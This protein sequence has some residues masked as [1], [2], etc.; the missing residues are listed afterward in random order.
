SFGDYYDPAHMGFGDLRVINDDRVAPARGFATHGHRDMEIVTWVLDGALSHEDSL[1][2]G[3]VI[4]PGEVQIMSAG[5]GI[6]HSEQN[7]SPVE[8]VHLLQI[9]IVPERR[10]LVPRYDQRPFP[11]DGLRL[12]VS[13]DGR[14][15]SLV[16]HQDASIHAGV[17]AAGERTTRA[18]APARRA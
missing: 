13:P 1:G 18:L 17:F 2:S 5:T 16:I 14:D 4:R 12:V 15:G 6:A 11:R 3:S 7:P 10:G 9:W 8:P